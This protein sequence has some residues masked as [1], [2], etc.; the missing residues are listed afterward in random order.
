MKLKTI[1]ISIFSFTFI[2]LSGFNLVFAEEIQDKS[3]EYNGLGYA[4]SILK[5]GITPPYSISNA[6]DEDI[7]TSTGAITLKQ[8][9]ISL[10]GR[11]GLD[12][13]LT[14]YY[15]QNNSTL[16]EPYATSSAVYGN[17]LAGY[18]VDTKVTVYTCVNGIVVSSYV[19]SSDTLIANGYS[20]A[21]NVSSYYNSIS[22]EYGSEYY[23]T[24]HQAYVY[25]VTS[26][27]AG[28]PYA[29]YVQACTGYTYSNNLN[30]VTSNEKYSSLGVGWSFDLP[31][32]ENISGYLYLNYGSAGTWQIDFSSSAGQSHLKNY[33]LID[34]K[35]NRDN[36]SYSNGQAS[37][38]YV[39]EQKDGRRTYFG[40]DGRLLGIKDRYNNEI[41]F[42]H[43]TST[44]SYPIVNKIIDSVGREINISYTK[45]QV[46]VTVNDASNSANNRTVK[47]NKTTI[48]GYSNDYV[49]DNVIDPLDR[50]TTYRYT[51]NSAKVNLLSKSISSGIT[52]Q[53]A[54]LTKV[55]SPTSGETCYAYSKITKNC[56]TDGVMEAYKLSERFDS[57]NDGE[58]VKYRKLNYLYGNTGEYDG[59]PNYRSDAAI[60]ETYTYK[61]QIVDNLNNSEIY[62]YNKKLLPLNI[63]REGADHKNETINEYDPV[64]RLLL[65]TCN[66]IFNKATNEFMQKNENYQYDS[67]GSRDLVGYWDCQASRDNN[68]MP[69]DNEHKVTF[70]Y[71]PTYHYTLTK[72]YKKDSATTIKE[73]YTPTSD[74]KAVQWKK[75]YQNGTLKS[76]TYYEYDVYG[77]VKEEKKFLDDGVTSVS[78]KYDYSDNQSER[79]GKF[80]GAYLTRKWADDVKNIDQVESNGPGSTVQETY[81]YDWYGNLVESIDAKNVS[82]TK[83]EVDKLNRVIKETHPD[84][85]Y[86]SWI[87]TTSSSE[88]STIVT[89]EK[90]TKIKYNFDKLG[91]L[92][93]EQ[94]LSSGEFLNQ[95]TYDSEM[96]LKTENNRN[97]SPSYRSITYNYLSDGKLAEKETIDQSNAVIDKETYTYN[98]ANENGS[99]TKV[100]KTVMGDANSPS[101]IS[102]TY[103]DKS[104]RLVKQGNVHNGVEYLDTF[105]YDYVGNKISEKTARAYDE[106]E[107][108]LN[109]EY[110]TKFDYD[111]AGNVIKTTNID[112][113]FSTAEYDA[114]GRLARTSDF[115]ANLTGQDNYWTSYE[116]DSL[117]RLIKET[118]PFQNEN[119]TLYSTIKKHYYD[120]NGNLLCDMLSNSKPGEALTFSETRYGYDTR[121]M[122]TDVTK[123]ENNS[124]ENYTQYYYDPTGNKL[125]M[126]TGLSSSLYIRGLDDVSSDD[127]SFSTNKYEYDRFNNLVKMTDPNGNT[128]IYSYDLNGNQLQKK[129]KNGSVINMTYDGNGRLLTKS[130]KNTENP[131]LNAS[132]TYTYTLIGKKKEMSGGGTNTEYFYDDLGRLVKEV[133]SNEIQKEYTYDVANN[134]KS[135]VIKQNELVKTN[136]TYTYDNM[137]RLEKVYE[138]GVLTATYQYDANGNR[139]SLTY[140]TGNKTTYMYNIA[141]QL[142]SITNT[143][144]GT[145]LSSYIYQYYLDGNQASKTDNKGKT[146]SYK[147]DGLGRL[148]NEIPSD[149]PAVSYAYDDS[150]NRK[151]MT[152]NGKSVTNYTYDKSNRL[153]AETTEENSELNIARYNYDNNGNTICKT[154]EKISPTIPDQTTEVN[155]STGGEQETTDLTLNEYDGF[156]QLIKTSTGDVTAEYSYDGT[157]LRTSKNVNG[158]VT[159]Q[160]WDGDQIALETDESGKIKNK[161][162]RGINLIYGEDELANKKFYLF[163]GHGDVTQLTDTSGSVIKNYDYDAFGNEKNPD[164]SDTNVFRYS[165]EYF[166]KETGTIYLRARYY[167]P[168]IGRFITEDSVWSKRI[169]LFNVTEDVQYTNLTGG[170]Y[171]K[172]EK[173]QYVIDDPLSLNLYT[174]CY[175]N[176]VMYCDPDGHFAIQ[177]VCA[178]IGGVAGWYF[179]DYVAKKLGYSSGWKYW[180]IRSGVTA[181]GAVIGWFAGAA[182]ANIAIDFL[183][184][185]SAVALQIPRWMLTGLG[186]YK[187]LN[188]GVNFS[189]TAAQRMEQSG[190]F[191][192]VNTLIDAI[193]NGTATKD[194]KG[195]RAIMY[196]IN[197]VK[198]GVTYKLE[199]LYDRASNS[200]WHFMYTKK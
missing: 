16:Y 197:M 55:I 184:A 110:T 78:T 77:N 82:P 37:S 168:G 165:G 126:Y 102:V 80:N 13:S 7:D 48:S 199:V 5:E 72:E 76:K 89:D 111:Y 25:D 59:Y 177:A 66:K 79:N 47:Y 2:L 134:R 28:S 147:Y 62:T 115:K 172:S 139:Q 119:G 183:V 20:D 153:L 92:E 61:T 128:E 39:L 69:L 8:T 57:K 154:T 85:S 127:E 113:T 131:S 121:N 97:S 3:G 155:L 56:G 104:S 6:Y 12:F 142:D 151:T 107:V 52:N 157:G 124:P 132:Y 70:T 200:I 11:N 161:Y 170:I 81:K 86:K 10:K 100:T 24:R 99:Y 152:I 41:K 46:L 189:T 140:S 135:L 114:L 64:T 22:D 1:F 51:I 129:D 35:L 158:T 109:R 34:M 14:R 30:N 149:E 160:I 159:N 38:Y 45:S 169:N 145:I 191:V 105:K 68:N 123:Y 196:Y 122:L 171:R 49:L 173:Q 75:I 198:N 40:N 190:R 120:E 143:K 18:C 67:S 84:A 36:Q 21:Q 26:Y 106:P 103:T 179:G 166:D 29:Y 98:N 138:N 88:N 17:V 63:L 32:I 148:T 156:N 101:I 116:Y 150:N 108:Y 162:V 180:A 182:I 4:Q 181:G 188:N 164:P 74:N 53:F 137:N 194:P 125:R 187:A 91:N 23:S 44:T 94:D 50:Q 176:A 19:A 58:K 192:P 31:Y 163:N 60:P 43:D 167:D 96:K 146:T 117:G 71:E 93:S 27:S 144:N 54:C 90:G 95:Y 33:P 141:N 130:V 193:R 178:A 133:S 195:S 112:G 175:N 15:T 185:N 118:V 186:Y 9:D 42:Q 73:E 136:T 83:Y 174:Y 65:K 87:Y